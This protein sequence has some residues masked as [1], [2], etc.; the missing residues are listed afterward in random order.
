MRILSDP[1]ET[2]A[3]C[4]ALPQ[5]VQTESYEYPEEFFNERV[6][7]IDRRPLSSESLEIITKLIQ[8]KKTPLTSGKFGLKILNIVKTMYRSAKTNKVEEVLA[9]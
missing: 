6:H 2:G 5:D 4:I 9:L 3:V 8:N 1:V 7:R